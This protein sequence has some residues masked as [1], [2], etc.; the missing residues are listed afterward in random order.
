[1]GRRWA[2]GSRRRT[3][4]T[5]S[6]SLAIA[7]VRRTPASCHLHDGQSRGCAARGR[8]PARC[9]CADRNGPHKHSIGQT[10]FLYCYEPGGN[11]F[12]IGAGGYLILDPDWKPVIWTQAER[13][14]GQAWG[15]QTVSTFHTHGTPP[16]PEPSRAFVSLARSAAGRWSRRLRSIPPG[17]LRG[18]PD[19]RLPVCPCRSDRPA[20]G[21]RNCD[22]WAITAAKP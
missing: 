22:R 21:G 3:S 13:A 7:A 2:R 11:R 12:E 15:L 9:R 8:H 5:T 1:M 18:L 16:V 20:A 6:P 19:R 14:K 17:G 10:F 4:R